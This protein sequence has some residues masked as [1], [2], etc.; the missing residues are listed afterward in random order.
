M[1]IVRRIIGGFLYLI[2]S[3]GC[4]ALCADSLSVTTGGYA[5]LEAG[6][7]VAG[8]WKQDKIDHVWQDRLLGGCSMAAHFNDRLEINVGLECMLAFGVVTSKS[9]YATDPEAYHGH[10]TFY[11]NILDGVY[12][13]GDSLNG[14]SIAAGYFPFAY[15]PDVRNFGEYL[16][17]GNAYPGYLMNDFDS[18]YKRLLGIHLDARLFGWLQQDLLITASVVDNPAQ[19][20]DISYLTAANVSHVLEFGAGV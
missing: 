11:P 9:N 2:A 20:A 1:T 7:I 8:Q 10:F 16:F 6:Q 5:S 4:L 12:N 17:R 15:N 13:K 18:I 19:D 3:G 14:W